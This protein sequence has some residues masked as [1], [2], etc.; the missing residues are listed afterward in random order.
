MASGKISKTKIAKLC[1]AAGLKFNPTRKTMKDGKRL[2]LVTKG[3][4]TFGFP[5]LDMLQNWLFNQLNARHNTVDH[6][7]HKPSKE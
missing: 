7:L 1:A 5:S 6:L 4:D 3:N 2:F